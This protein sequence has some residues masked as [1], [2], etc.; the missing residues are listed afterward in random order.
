MADQ[1]GP[2]A[3][4]P[5][6][7]RPRPG[8]RVA[9]AGHGLLATA[10]SESLSAGPCIDHVRAYDLTGIS[11]FL[12]RAGLAGDADPPDSRV[13]VTASDGWD[14][15]DYERIQALCAAGWTS[16]LPVRTELGRTVLGPFYTPGE[17]GCVQCAEQ[18]RSLANEH[19]AARESVRS[20]V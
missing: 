18:R 14:C 10:I 8:Q 7:A 1:G 6:G 17:A 19:Y 5:E 13:L 20:S 2:T 9:I 16:W 11:G 3:N 15:R 12:D 4:R